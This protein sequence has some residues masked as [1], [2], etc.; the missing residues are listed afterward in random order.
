ME[1]LSAADLKLK[2]KQNLQNILGY[3]II[4]LAFIG[5]CTLIFLGV[6]GVESLFDDSDERLEFQKLISTVVMHDPAPF[7]DPVNAGDD[8]LLQSAAWAVV[9]NENPDRYSYDESGAM[10]IPAADLDLYAAKIFGTDVKLSHQT[11][12]SSSELEFTYIEETNMYKVPVV[13]ML[14]Y[15][16]PYV[17]DMKKSG[18]TIA[19]KVGY[20]SGT[21]TWMGDINGQVYTPEVD[22]YMLYTMEKTDKDNYV[23]KSISY[24]TES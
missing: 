16:T 21:N 18:D 20:V 5:L 7:D 23:L 6:K 1:N 10:L 17:T 24:Y 19:L 2:K 22:K 4:A 9:K 12:G 3:A 15:Y 8:L 11:F 13:G 14:G